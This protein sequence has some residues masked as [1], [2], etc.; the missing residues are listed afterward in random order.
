[1]AAAPQWVP[2]PVPLPS[3]AR[4]ADQP[5]AHLASTDAT[6]IPG[7]MGIPSPAYAFP[8]FQI[9]GSPPAPP[10]GGGGGGSTPPVLPPD[11]GTGP[12]PVTPPIT[13][14]GGRPV[15]PAPD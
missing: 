13:E 5:M 3:H 14:P 12:G 6:R 10:G 8:G 9:G 4:W 2:A 11:P 7:P 1:M 15:T